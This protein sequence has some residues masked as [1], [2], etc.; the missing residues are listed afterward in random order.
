VTLH[1]TGWTPDGVM[2]ESSRNREQPSI[3]DVDEVMPGWREALPLLSEGDR[4]RLWL[5]EALAYQ[6]GGGEPK[7]AVVF[8]VELLSVERRP[9]PP[10]PPE[11]LKAPPRDAKRT[12][13]GLAYRI[14]SSGHGTRKPTPS[15]RVQV[16]Y[17]A[18]SRD[19]QLFDSS[20]VRGKPTTVPVSHVVPGWAEGLQ[21][22]VEGDKALFWIPEKL[23]YGGKH[24]APRGMLVYEV[25][26][27]KI[28]P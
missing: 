20:V 5:P 27:L 4:A 14:V 15:D 19:G 2:F 11:H 28:A 22:M 24:A 21:L 16:H 9:E 3:F 12:A 25:E 17:S 6:K 10:R 18:W 23:A 26:L 8:D 13:S 7:G 1:Y